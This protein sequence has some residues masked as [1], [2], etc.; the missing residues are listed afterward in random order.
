MG[1]PKMVRTVI[2]SSEASSQ[3]NCSPSLGRRT[4][5]SY[6]NVTSGFPKKGKHFEFL[7]LRKRQP[8][9]VDGSCEYIE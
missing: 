9:N 8:A 6:H 3:S 4:I 2:L 7:L 5:I 1:R